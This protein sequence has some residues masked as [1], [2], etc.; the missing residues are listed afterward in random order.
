MTLTLKFHIATVGLEGGLQFCMQV[1]NW[2][3]L[4]C[5]HCRGKKHQRISFH[6]KGN[7]SSNRLLVLETHFLWKH[8]MI[9]KQ[10]TT[11]R[12]ASLFWGSPDLSLPAPLHSPTFLGG[13]KVVHS[14][15]STLLQS[16]KRKTCKTQLTSLLL[17]RVDVSPE[18]KMCY[19]LATLDLCDSA[20]ANLQFHRVVSL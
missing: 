13:P 11:S 10:H 3:T 7:C 19:D 1:R 2:A 4:T 17:Q 18:V 14:S 6:F 16:D 5:S 9:R 15:L 20:L 8:W 12:W